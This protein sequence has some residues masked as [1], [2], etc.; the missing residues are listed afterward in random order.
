MKYASKILLRIA[1]ATVIIIIAG[2]AWLI[3]DARVTKDSGISEKRNTA[4]FFADDFYSALSKLPTSSECNRKFKAG[5]TTHHRLASELV[6][7]LF[8]C[9]KNSGHPKTV[10]LIGPNHYLGGRRDVVTARNDWQ[11]PFGIME[12]DT[13]IIAGIQSS[14][15]VEINDQVV[16]HDHA[17]AFIV[18]YIEYYLPNT[19]IVP[20]L[21]RHSITKS[22]LEGFI[23]KLAAFVNEE[24]MIIGSVD[25]SHYQDSE[26]AARYD[27][28]TAIIV[29]KRDL[30]SVYQNGDEHYDSAPAIYLILSLMNISDSVSTF[31]LNHSSSTEYTGANQNITTYFNWL[32]Y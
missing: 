3:V 30:A 29:E 28:E 18:P 6:D 1:P 15:A 16:E 14:S 22:E 17:V 23:K 9:I 19:K 25:F 5:I 20:I 24:T 26:S 31:Q 13:D 2:L 8:R 12:A 4:Q 27:E 21:I 10:I 32:F 7:Q 11:T